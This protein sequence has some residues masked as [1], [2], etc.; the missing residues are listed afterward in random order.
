MCLNMKIRAYKKKDKEPI[1][2]FISSILMEIFN[3]N[4]TEGLEDLDDIDNNFDV[5]YIIE[6]NKEII[7]TIGVKNQRDGRISRMYI[8]KS[9]RGKG[10]GRRLMEKALD[11]CKNKY[12]RLFLTTYPQL[13]SYGFYKKMGFKEFKRDKR[14]WMEKYQKK[15]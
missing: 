14:I 1:K 4:Y 13:N 9:E 10:Y 8:R 6:K 3:V 15:H 2:E 11:F 7:G 5:F 12:N